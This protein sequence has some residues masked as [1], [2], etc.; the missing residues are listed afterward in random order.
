MMSKRL[1]DFI[2][3]PLN[4]YFESATMVTG[5]SV[6]T[7]VRLCDFSVEQLHALTFC[8][9]QL[10]GAIF[11]KSLRLSGRARLEHNVGKITTMISTD[12]AR[13]DRSAAFA[14][15]YVFWGYFVICLF[16]RSIS[17][18]FSVWVGPIQVSPLYYIIIID[19][20]LWTRSLLQSVSFSEMC[21]LFSIFIQLLCR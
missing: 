2:E 10:I 15:K 21:A 5:V 17:A 3:Q 18:H 6:R 8:A 16:I 7:A 4:R 14:H 9:S 19:N 1:L 12:T 20:L 13:L 11:R